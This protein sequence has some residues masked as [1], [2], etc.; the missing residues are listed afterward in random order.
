M[1]C[2]I[3]GA[4]E[5]PNITIYENENYI[6]RKE[7]YGETNKKEGD[8]LDEYLQRFIPETLQMLFITDK[9]I[10]GRKIIEDQDKFIQGVVRKASE[11]EAF[12]DMFQRLKNLYDKHKKTTNEI[13]MKK[14]TGKE[15]KADTLSKQSKDLERE[16][17]SIKK[18]IEKLEE[19]KKEN[20]SFIEKNEPKQELIR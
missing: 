7:I 13:I 1:E 11:Y 15:K 8:E 9:E 18:K 17:E 2:N 19:K 5:M 6:V 20:E 12:D 3:S 16:N 4:L 14:L 10:L